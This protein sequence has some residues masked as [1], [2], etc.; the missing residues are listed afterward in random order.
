MFPKALYT[1]DL[2]LLA[3]CPHLHCYYYSYVIYIF[4]IDNK[5]HKRPEGSAPIRK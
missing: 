1:T 5:R 2:L 3:R 4:F